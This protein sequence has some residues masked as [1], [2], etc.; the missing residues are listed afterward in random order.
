MENIMQIFNKFIFLFTELS[1]LFLGI[2]F[3]VQLIQQKLSSEKIQAILGRQKGWLGYLMSAFLGSITPFCTCSTVPLLKGFIKA[4]VGFGAMMTFLFT[5]PLLNPI[6][7][8]M[9]WAMLGMKI[10]IIYFIFALIFAIIAS[11]LLEKWG[12]ERFLISYTNSNECCA[13][14]SSCCAKTSCE[15][16]KNNKLRSMKFHT[17]LIKALT[18][19]WKEFQRVFFHLII[20]C[21]IGAFVYEK[22]PTEFLQ[23]YIGSDNFF[24]I[25][26]AAII[27][28]PLYVRTSVL[29]P[30]SSVLIEKGVSLGAMMALIIGG[31]GASLPEIILLKSIFKK[32]LLIAFIV[33]IMIMAI[34]A[35]LTTSIFVG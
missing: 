10:T 23:R 5:S 24:S 13:S 30:L 22:V 6:I 7:I 9:F 20:S 11:V 25:P 26:I 32:E 34:G 16:T 21:I 27:G 3:I 33:V 2:T 1:V 18:D 29:I 17:I 15:S 19:S 31:G 28:I 14:E 8:G 12:F 35:G 4:K